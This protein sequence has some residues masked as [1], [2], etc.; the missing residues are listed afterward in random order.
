ME[1]MDLCLVGPPVEIAAVS[2]EACEPLAAHLRDVEVHVSFL[3][4]HELHALLVVHT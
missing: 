4:I 3:G 1:F 2:I